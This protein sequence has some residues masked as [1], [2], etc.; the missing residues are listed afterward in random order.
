M[1]VGE[2]PGTPSQFSRSA[3][4]SA[5]PPRYTQNHVCQTHFQDPGTAVGSRCTHLH[6]THIDVNTASQLAGPSHQV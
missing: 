4:L 1:E 6:V 5:V 2:E 3:F